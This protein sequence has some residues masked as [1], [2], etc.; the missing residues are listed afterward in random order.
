MDLEVDFNNDRDYRSRIYQD[1]HHHEP[2]LELLQIDMIDG[3]P[4]DYLHCVLLGVVNWILDYLHNT[5][6]M[7]SCSDY[8]TIKDRIEKFE[9]TR[10]V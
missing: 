10:P 1:Y 5:S 6:Q 2:V 9:K 7:L 8:A 4:L 3:F